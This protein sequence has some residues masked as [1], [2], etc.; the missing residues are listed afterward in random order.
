LCG[1]K[2]DTVESDGHWRVGFASARSFS[3]C[4]SWPRR[5]FLVDSI[6]KLLLAAIALGLWANA[7]VH[8]IGP[9]M[10]DDDYHVRQIQTIIENIAK[11][12]CNNHKI[13]G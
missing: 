10:A 8:T 1:L 2:F 4:R 11:G 9:A 12:T 7:A 6:A 3:V 5:G 13:C